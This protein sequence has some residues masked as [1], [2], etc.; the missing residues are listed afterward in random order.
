MKT[1]VN[2][3]SQE[4]P[5]S[6]YLFIKEQYEEGDRLLF[7]SAKDTEATLKHIISFVGLPS[8]LVE[9]VVLERDGD[10]HF[11][12]RICRALR[13]SGFLR[14]GNR[15]H[16]NLAG[17]TRYMALAVRQAFEKYNPQYYY[18]DVV[19]NMIINTIYDDSIDDNDD[20]FLTIRHR[21]SIAEYLELHHMQHDMEEESAHKPLRSAED[22]R[23]LF[24]G[25]TQSFLPDED[26]HAIEKLREGYRNAYSRHGRQ[27][28]HRLKRMDSVPIEQMEHPTDREWIPVPGLTR[29]LQ[30]IAFVPAEKGMLSKAEISY[31]TGGWFEE[32]V[33]HRV[34]ELYHPDDVAISVRIWKDE[35]HE[36]E[37]DV[38]YTKA[39]KLYVI[40]CKTGVDNKKM[41]NEIVYKACALKDALLG[42]SCRFFIYSL[43][44]DADGLLKTTARNMGITFCDRE[45]LMK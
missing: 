26:F 38:V 9:S 28:L 10:K 1:L 15:Y 13:D 37:L 43:K 27:I 36:N 40:E 34:V 45:Y 11:Y 32:Y 41:F 18:L 30:H 17:G 2:I 23:R 22:S 29:F 35:S 4:N 31:L 24:Q 3:I 33:Y 6:A 16:V 25:F 12:E 7:V 42:I 44:P 19:N 21:M 39:N 8:Q 14:E 5:I 20:E